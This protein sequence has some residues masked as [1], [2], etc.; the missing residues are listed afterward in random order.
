MP[1][2]PAA[3]PSICFARLG[4]ID[5]IEQEKQTQ[6]KL[7][8]LLLNIENPERAS[9]EYRMV[10]WGQNFEH[11]HPVKFCKYVYTPDDP[12]A[13]ANVTKALNINH[14]PTVI[15]LNNGKELDR[16]TDLNE[17][18]PN[19]S[20]PLETDKIDQDEQR[21]KDKTIQLCDNVGK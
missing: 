7:V 1:P 15:F 4:S 21:V 10:N 17:S 19:R 12:E 16:I 8:V 9:L 3:N 14:Q 11:S 20:H 5:A 13:A 18:D 6:D 2:K